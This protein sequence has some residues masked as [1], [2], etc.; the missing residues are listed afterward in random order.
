M[1][2]GEPS[3]RIALFRPAENEDKIRVNLDL[4][5]EA[6]KGISRQSPS[7]QTPR[8]KVSPQ[9]LPTLRPGLEKDSR[10]QSKRSL[11]GTKKTCE[12]GQKDPLQTQTKDLRGRPKRSPL[13]TNKRSERTVKEIPSRH[14]QKT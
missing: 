5:Q 8:M 3:P 14:E 11:P 10:G 12:D 13:G 1:E 4:L 9:T 2:I 7:R 6:H